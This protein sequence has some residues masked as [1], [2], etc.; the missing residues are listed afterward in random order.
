MAERPTVKEIL[1][2]ARQ[3]GA[4]KPA[5]A[6]APPGRRGTGG[7]SGGF[8]CSISEAEPEPTAPPV[9]APAAPLGRPMTL[10]EK[11]AAARAGGAALPGSRSPRPAAK[12]AAAV[13]NPPRRKRRRL[14]RPSL[15]G[16]CPFPRRRWAGR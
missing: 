9:A 13:P 7:C 2:L 4:A 1:A 3:G 16:R 14:P 11:L 10:K 12:L 5:E 6:A 15:P 8:Y